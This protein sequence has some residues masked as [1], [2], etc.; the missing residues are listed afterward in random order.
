MV[1]EFIFVVKP[2]DS[3]KPGDIVFYDQAGLMRFAQEEGPGV[4]HYEEGRR[5][6]RSF[7]PGSMSA[8]RGGHYGPKRVVRGGHN[9]LD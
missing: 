7:S 3:T 9:E 2:S 5:K 8:G 6:P 4:V 1:N